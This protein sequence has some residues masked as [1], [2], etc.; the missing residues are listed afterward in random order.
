M[1]CAAGRQE[2]IL[3]RVFA[4]FIHHDNAKQTILSNLGQ[5]KAPERNVFSLF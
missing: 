2:T 1:V 3:R 5:P 4:G